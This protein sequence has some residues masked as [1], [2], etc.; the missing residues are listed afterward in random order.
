MGIRS[1]TR[2]QMHPVQAAPRQRLFFGSLIIAGRDAPRA[3]SAEAKGKA[4]YDGL[5][6][7]DAP[8]AG[9]AEAKNRIRMRDLSEPRCTPCRQR[10]AK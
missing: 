2:P 4:D 1:K 5:A 3:G 6:D 9:S 8:R 7:E 10:T